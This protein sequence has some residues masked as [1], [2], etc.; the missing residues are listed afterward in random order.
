[1]KT[2]FCYR[3]SGLEDLSRVDGSL[4]LLELGVDKYVAL[5]MKHLLEKHAALVF[6]TDEVRYHIHARRPDLGG[7]VLLLGSLSRHPD[8]R[9]FVPTFVINNI[10][11][12]SS[13]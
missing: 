8:M 12:I 5:E 1:M 13:Q 3:I 4:S 7:T 10:R 9:Q 6:K 2:D 11:S